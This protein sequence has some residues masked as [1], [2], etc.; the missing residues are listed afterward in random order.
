MRDESGFTLVELTVTMAILSVVSL[1][2]FVFINQMTNVSSRAIND[3]VTENN[4][5]LVLRTM[6]E[7][8][9]AASPSTITFTGPASTCPTSSTAGT[10]LSFT[11]LRN[12][13]T[14]PSCQS[15]IIYGLLP[16]TIAE[17]RTDTGCAANLTLT[18]K[19]ILSGVTNGTTPLFAYYDK[20]GTALT[21]GQA[22]AASIGVTLIV[23][24]QTNS[25]A[26]TFS[27]YASLRNA[28]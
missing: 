11:I 8:L 19:T 18:G 1:M 14:Y 28:R 16:S 22:A 12:T 9:R 23:Q 26:L 21:T 27:G 20:Q 25:P 13:S 5:R 17:T 2:A 3:V 6:T 24:Y 15:S 7:D 10:C 4:A